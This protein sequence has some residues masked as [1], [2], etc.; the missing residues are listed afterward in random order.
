MLDILCLNGL[1]FVYLSSFVNAAVVLTPSATLATLASSG[2]SGWP[3]LITTVSEAALSRR[4]EKT[5]GN[6]CVCTQKDLLS[7]P[8]SQYCVYDNSKLAVGCCSVDSDG[9]FVSNCVVPTKCLD[10]AESSQS[11]PTSG[12]G[13]RTTLW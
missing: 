6:A 4:A 3:P 8:K 9:N 7:C 1:L 2:L 11:C 13:G 10:L 5:L 12:C